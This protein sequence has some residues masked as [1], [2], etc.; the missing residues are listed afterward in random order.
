MS[1]RKVM[2]T[3]EKFLEDFDN[4][5]LLGGNSDKQRYFPAIVG[6]DIQN[7]RVVYDLDKLIDIFMEKDHM[8]HDDALEYIEYNVFRV[9]PYIENPPIIMTNISSLGISNEKSE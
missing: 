6:I 3:L 9:L 2:E 8:S 4:I 7:N 1:E 5:M